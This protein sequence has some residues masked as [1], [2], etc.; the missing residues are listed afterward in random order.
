MALRAWV[1]TVFP[2]LAF[3]CDQKTDIIR[4]AGLR[5]AGERPGFPNGTIFWMQ[6][7]ME[8]R[9]TPTEAEAVERLCR[10]EVRLPPLALRLVET[11]DQRANGQYD[12]IVGAA[13]RGREY[14]FALEYKSRSTPKVFRETVARMKV[15]ERP[16]NTCPMLMTPFLSAGQLGDL[17]QTEVS[18]IDLCGNGVVIVPGELCVFRSGQPNR[19]P[20]SDPIKNIYRGQSSLVPRVFF[21]RAEY[22]A[23]NEVKREIEARKG[24]IA[25]STISKALA[26]LNEDLFIS[27]R[28]GRIRLLQADALLDKL[29][30]NYA[31]PRTRRRLIGRWEG[32]SSRFLAGLF[33]EAERASVRAVVSGASSVGRY[34]VMAREDRIRIYCDNIDTFVRTAGG[35]FG[36]TS[37]FSNLELIETRDDFVYFDA[38]PE[39]G[40]WYACPVQAYLELMAG[41]KRDRETAAQVRRGI[42]LE[43]PTS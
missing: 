38:R 21:A 5:N 6:K 40:V 34:A 36:E 37:R 22:G 42:L 3:F 10:G 29:V 41:D 25:L 26:T 19:Y 9:K 39:A 31:A 33:D 18:G 2:Y 4:K 1:L 16:P 12:A 27:R 43:L 23:V 28:E 24:R 15:D 20:Q 7:M 8:H 14:R 11:P 32:E 17:E 13:W 30:A 35:F